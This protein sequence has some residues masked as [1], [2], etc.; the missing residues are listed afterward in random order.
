MPAESESSAKADQ[1]GWFGKLLQTLNMDA[2]VRFAIL[3]RFWQL[4]TGPLTQM[5]IVYQFS[6]ARQDYYQAFSRMLGMQIFVELGLGVVLINVASHE[7]ARL[8]M[9]SSGRIEGDRE[10]LSRLVSLGRMMV[11]WYGVA[12]LVFVVAISA[13]GILFFRDTESLQL[14][15]AGARERIL[16]FSPWVALVLLTGG[17]LAFLPL[18]SILEGCNQLNE[19]NRVRFWQAVAGTI[20]VWAMVVLGCGL[21][22]LVGSAA[23]RLAADAWLVC[24]RFRPFFESF[25]AASSGPQV[26]WRTEILPLQWR[27]AVQG[28]LLWMASQLPLLVIFRY[29]EEGR[30]TQLGMTWTILTALQS[31]S[32]AWIETRRPV[33]GSLIAERRFVELDRLFFRMTRFSMMGMVAGTGAFC[34]TVWWLGTRNEWLFDRL[35]GRMLPLFPTLLFSVAMIV[36]QFALCTNLYVRAHKK[37]PFLV[38]SVVSSSV[39]AGLQFWLGRYYGTT[40]VAAGYLAGIALVQVPLWT[41]IWWTTRREWHRPGAA[42]G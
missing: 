16:W 18:T 39:I 9:N 3:A 6:A 19:L 38:A 25:R 36:Y 15:E 14:A 32:L 29:D 37:D 41:I 13:A 5:L 2:A 12:T 23:V 4:I 35:S 20:T 7:W 30:A 10:S 11:K 26:Q 28:I 8:S 21:W 34:A 27:I 33:F 24:H 40:G 1:P 17:Q 31:A 22:A 42:H